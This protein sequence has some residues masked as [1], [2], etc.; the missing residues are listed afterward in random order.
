MCHK[1]IH[2]VYYFIIISEHYRTN[3][4]SNNN[5][6]IVYLNKQHLH[7]YSK[8]CLMLLFIL[9]LSL[10]LACCPSMYISA[11]EGKIE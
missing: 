8:N 2:N 10:Q 6:S 3:V 5:D 1:I 11:A 4:A 9:G 7:I